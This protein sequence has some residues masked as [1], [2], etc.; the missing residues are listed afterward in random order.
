MITVRQCR[1]EDAPTLWALNAL[2]N[3]GSTADPTVPLPL[4]PTRE[5]PA[6][7]P[8]LADIPASFHRVGGDFLVAELDGHLVGMG[9]IRPNSSGQAEVLR[10]RVHRRYD[11][12]VSDGH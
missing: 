4:A 6:N 5:P 7:F 1:S 9:G 12:S 2:P 11:V 10:V 8:D 3:I